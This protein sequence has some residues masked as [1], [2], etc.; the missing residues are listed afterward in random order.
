M[1]SRNLQF[2]KKKIKNS[3]YT[4]IS[5]EVPKNSILMAVRGYQ[6]DGFFCF[7]EFFKQLTT[8]DLLKFT[9]IRFEI[10]R[11]SSFMLVLCAQTILRITD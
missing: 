1:I 3:F 2:Y 11:P 7:L 4:V 8:G 5:P 6:N 10:S 9:K